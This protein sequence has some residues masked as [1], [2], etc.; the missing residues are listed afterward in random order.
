MKT[1]DYTYNFPKQVIIRSCK[2][3]GS[4]IVFLTTLDFLCF[5][6]SLRHVGE[7]PIAMYDGQ[8]LWGIP[9]CGNFRQGN[10]ETAPRSSEVPR[11]RSA[12]L[13]VNLD[14]LLDPGV[15]LGSNM[16]YHSYWGRISNLTHTIISNAVVHWVVQPQPGFF[17]SV[18]SVCQ[19]VL[20]LQRSEVPQ[21][22][23]PRY[24]CFRGL[25]QQ[26]NRIE[27]GKW[28]QANFQ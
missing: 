12:S 23:N 26:V 15:L 19:F 9:F 17:S 7:M 20:L 16:S 25:Q 8:S 27:I 10:G 2:Y 11:L 3:A 24:C 18:W 14:D 21:S 6:F 13:D 22:N 1:Y 28:S 4:F 5:L